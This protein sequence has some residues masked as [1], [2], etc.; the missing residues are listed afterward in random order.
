MNSRDKLIQQ[1]ADEWIYST[2]NRL[3]HLA[4]D[5]NQF[6]DRINQ[7]LAKQDKEVALLILLVALN[8]NI[9]GNTPLTIILSFLGVK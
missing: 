5:L 4:E 3:T 7:Q 8:T 1:I 2:E 6:K 9:G